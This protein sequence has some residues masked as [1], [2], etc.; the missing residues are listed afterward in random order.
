MTVA[1]SK[2]RTGIALASEIV[3]A[4]DTARDGNG[5]TTRAELV[6]ILDGEGYGKGAM[7]RGTLALRADAR[8]AA[9][10][11]APEAKD[12]E[13][14]AKQTLKAI[15]AAAAKDG[16]KGELSKD[17]FQTLTAREKAAVRFA[18]EYGDRSFDELFF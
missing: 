9:G 13:A 17:E 14:A 11:R 10:N 2:I 8:V 5:R 3:Q 6:S 15:A 1:L 18:Q 7:R 12:V 16:K 4:A